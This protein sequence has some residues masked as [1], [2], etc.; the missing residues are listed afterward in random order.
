MIRC[1]TQGGGVLDREYIFRD[2]RTVPESIES[3][4]IQGDS[5]SWNVSGM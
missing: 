2:E 4:Q 5:M 3:F 1:G